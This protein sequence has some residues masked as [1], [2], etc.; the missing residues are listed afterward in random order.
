MG[1]VY[2]FQAQICL[3]SSLY[4]HVQIFTFS[5][6]YQQTGNGR[7]PSVWRPRFYICC[8]IRWNQEGTSSLEARSL[9]SILHYE[10]MHLWYKYIGLKGYKLT[11]GS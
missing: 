3:S 11:A 5:T 8:D 6:T 7:V 1:P 10:Y 2:R 4:L 9:S